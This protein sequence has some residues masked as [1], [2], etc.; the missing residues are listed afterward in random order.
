MWVH[1]HLEGGVSVCVVYR[2]TTLCVF[3][4]ACVQHKDKAGFLW[5]HVQAA[6][7]FQD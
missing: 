5:G 1:V 2:C 4:R 6:G 3:V 7:H